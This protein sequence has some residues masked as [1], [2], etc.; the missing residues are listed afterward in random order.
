LSTPVF[1][2]SGTNLAGQPPK[3]ANASTWLAVQDAWSMLTT[4]RTNMC[5]ECDNTIT[6]AQILCERPVRGSVQDP[7]S[8]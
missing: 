4:G 2:L 3:N 6:N 5:R 8:P 7:S 1:K